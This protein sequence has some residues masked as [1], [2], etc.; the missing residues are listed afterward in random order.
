VKFRRHVPPSAEAV[1]WRAR[2]QD[3]RRRYL[4]HAVAFVGALLAGYLVAALVLF[5]APVFVTSST[6]PRVIGISA[7]SARRLLE[8][9]DLR[10]REAERNPHPRAP[11]GQV[12][13]Q[14]P[15]PGVVATE[16]TT[17]E[18]ALS[19]GPQ[20]VPVPDLAGY[21]GNTARMLLEGAGFTAAVESLQTAAARGVVVNS[22]P[23]TGTVREPGSTITLVISR[24]APT[25]SVPNLAG[26]TLDEAQTILEQTGLRLGTSL[27]RTAAEPPGTVIEQ[28]P[29]GGTLAAPGTSVDI[30][31][32]RA[33]TP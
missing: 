30:V 9:A 25:I 14:D 17:V 29:R 6:V 10:V 2:L 4:W 32:S 28:R 23:P 24:G 7:D 22:R 16:G 19:S 1:A 18:I 31:V 33:T 20:R 21:D 5:R 15:P 3:A 12:T 8:D 26:F 27:M 13:W 11:A